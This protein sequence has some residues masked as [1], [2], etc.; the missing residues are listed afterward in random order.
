[1]GA[2]LVALHLVAV[3]LLA[4][5]PMSGTWVPAGSVVPLHTIRQYLELGPAAA[6]HH[7]ATGLS[8]LAPLGV[9]LP[10]AGGRVTT[11]APGSFARTAF[12][13]LMLAFGA[14]VVRTGM[15][16]SVFDVDVVLLN[17]LGV[18]LAHLAV[19]P[20]ARAALRRRGYGQAAEAWTTDAAVGTAGAGAAGSGPVGAAGPGPV[21]GA[22]AGSGAAMPSV[23]LVP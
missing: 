2:A 21:A 23:R 15:A 20:A 22:G 14:E 5:R 7:L 12:G 6:V 4:L 18:V 17:T 13:G 8:L 16:G 9:L 3:Y 10:L 11:S 19:V 1:M